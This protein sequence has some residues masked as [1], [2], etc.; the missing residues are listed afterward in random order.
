MGG[1]GQV[2]LALIEWKANLEA[3]GTWMGRKQARP[4]HI[5]C[6]EGHAEI[7]RILTRQRADAEAQTATHISP[8]CLAAQ[9]GHV[10][11][12]TELLAARV[13]INRPCY[14]RGTTALMIA[15]KWNRFSTV[16]VLMTA[17]ANVNL[18]DMFGKT[19]M[20]VCKA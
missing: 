1:S 4:L 6:L 13:E 17:K 8:L 7:V 16:S 18:K 5:A 2:M 12:I 20:D 19:A 11:A 3:A 9:E 10:Y 15:A 14:D